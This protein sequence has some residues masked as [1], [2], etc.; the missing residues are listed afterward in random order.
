MR[1]DYNE[2][3]VTSEKINCRKARSMS[4]FR[5]AQSQTDSCYGYKPS[6]ADINYKDR[7]KEGNDPLVSDLRNDNVWKA[8][9]NKLKYS[10]MKS[11]IAIEDITRK[12]VG[13]RH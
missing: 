9:S 3:D 12:T 10:L 8:R 2:V 13:M 5:K 4:Q 1:E 11:E 7:N 6:S